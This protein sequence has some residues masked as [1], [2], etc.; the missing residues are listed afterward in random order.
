MATVEHTLD[1]KIFEALRASTFTD[2]AYLK[3]HADLLVH[4]ALYEQESNDINL[5]N[6]KR[7]IDSSTAA[8]NGVIRSRHDV[9]E[10][11]E[12]RTVAK[13]CP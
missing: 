13:L 4:A 2:A 10:A 3:A 11:I 6:L 1:V 12:E 5:E 9:G 7:A 8:M